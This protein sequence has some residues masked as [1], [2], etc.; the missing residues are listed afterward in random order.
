LE[1]ARTYSHL[2]GRPFF[3]P[4]CPFM[5]KMFLICGCGQDAV[6]NLAF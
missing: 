1:S 5:L 6:M 3:I 2:F 4:V